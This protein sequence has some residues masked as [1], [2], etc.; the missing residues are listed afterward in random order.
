V[1]HLD[2]QK[3]EGVENESIEQIAFADKVLLN[4]VRLSMSQ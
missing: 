1:Q 4:K 2:E 3:P